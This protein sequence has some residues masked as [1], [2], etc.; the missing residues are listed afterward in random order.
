M[1]EDKKKTIHKDALALKNHVTENF[2]DDK[3]ANL[4]KHIGAMLSIMAE[5]LESDVAN[6]NKKGLDVVPFLQFWVVKKNANGDYTATFKSHS[7]AR[8]LTTLFN[9]N[10][11][12]VS[13][14]MRE[15]FYQV[16]TKPPV[17]LKYINELAALAKNQGEAAELYAPRNLIYLF[18]VIM[19]S[20]LEIVYAQDDVWLTLSPIGKFTRCF[21]LNRSSHED[22]LKGGVL[23][24]YPTYLT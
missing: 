21:R 5:K 4:H 24:F 9:E 20:L 11:Q 12:K 15:Y 16:L 14:K 18:K 7:F 3:Q 19:L 23:Q 1:T 17:F 10:N 2:S 22:K 13:P 8:Q 6:A